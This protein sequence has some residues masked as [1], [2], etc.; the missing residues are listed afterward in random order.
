MSD[1]AT[2]AVDATATAP[3]VVAK[4]EATF[5]HAVQLVVAVD[6]DIPKAIEALNNPLLMSAVGLAHLE[7]VRA[8]LAAF[9]NFT[10]RFADALLAI[11]PP[12]KLAT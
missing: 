7:P 6:G 10:K 1:E 8:D 2:P 5:E 12:P 3:D 4:L 11:F 9:L